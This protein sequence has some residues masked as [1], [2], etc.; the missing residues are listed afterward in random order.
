MDIA[1]AAKLVINNQ[2]VVNWRRVY[3]RD[4]RPQHQA[5]PALLDVDELGVGDVVFVSRP[6]DF[7]NSNPQHSYDANGLLLSIERPAN[8]Q[9]PL[10]EF[11]AAEM[12]HAVAPDSFL[13]VATFNHPSQVSLVPPNNPIEVS[14]VSGTYAAGVYIDTSETGEKYIGAS[15]QFRGIQGA[16]LGLPHTGIGNP[17]AIDQQFV[18]EILSG[19]TFTVALSVNRTADGASG[20]AYLFVGKEEAAFVPPFK[21][22]DIPFTT[23]TNVFWLRAGIGT[24][25]DGFGYKA[26]VD[27]LDFQIWTPF[28]PYISPQ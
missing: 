24:A 5:H 12:P 26:S 13:F 15:C 18:D 28:P 8:A 7:P 6:P 20:S 21:F 11:A 4:F 19:K 22:S 9:E 2:P 1:H 25:I 14:L 27:L 16:T 10:G 17:K 23:S 3:F